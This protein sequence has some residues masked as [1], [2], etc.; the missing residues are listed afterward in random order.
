MEC[1]NKCEKWYHQQ[2]V[3][4]TPDIKIWMCSI[5]QLSNLLKLLIFVVLV[6]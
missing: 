2:Y 5:L 1:D 6:D 4:Y 3:V